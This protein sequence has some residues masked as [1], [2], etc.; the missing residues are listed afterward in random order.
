[1][2]RSFIIVNILIRLPTT[3]MYSHSS[4]QGCD[5]LCEACI[6]APKLSDVSLDDSLLAQ[7]PLN[8]SQRTTDRDC[9]AGIVSLVG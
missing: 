5:L 3:P 9:S 6:P 4:A 2:F 7:N 1:M 8:E